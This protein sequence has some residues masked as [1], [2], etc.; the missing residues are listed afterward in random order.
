MTV[1]K[2]PITDHQGNLLRPPPNPEPI[3]SFS[4]SSRLLTY[5]NS[6]SIEVS[7]GRGSCGRSVG[8]GVSACLTYMNLGGGD[9]QSSAGHLQQR[10][11]RSL[12]KRLSWNL[13]APLPRG[14]VQFLLTEAKQKV[15]LVSSILLI[16]ECSHP[17]LSLKGNLLYSLVG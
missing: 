10:R 4:G 7:T 1:A 9:F 12:G 2:D 13:A 14:E 17:W 11:H 8:D 15:N 6:L 3:S 16:P 5:I